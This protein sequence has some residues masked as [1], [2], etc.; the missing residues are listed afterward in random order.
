MTRL[1]PMKRHTTS[2]TAKRALPI[3]QWMKPN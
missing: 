3:I 2:P 1:C